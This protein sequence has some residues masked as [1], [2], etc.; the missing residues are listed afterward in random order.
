MISNNVML[1]CVESDEPVLP[2]LSLKTPNDVLS[3]A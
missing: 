3:V 1:T 2:L